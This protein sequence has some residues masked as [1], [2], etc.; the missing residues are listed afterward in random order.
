MSNEEKYGIQETE[1]LFDLAVSLKEAVAKA[2]EGDGKID[3]KTDFIH[4]FQPVTRIPRAFEGAGNI[5]KEWSDLS[6]AEIIRLHDRFGDIVNDER[7]QRAFIGL[8]IAGDA[9]YEIVSEEKA[10]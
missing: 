8:A 1:D 6:E 7:W 3:I 2:K 5:P 4:F 10:A 9:I